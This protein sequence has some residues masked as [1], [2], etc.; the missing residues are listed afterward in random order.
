MWIVLLWLERE[1]GKHVV[2]ILI[3]KTS[4]FSGK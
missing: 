4:R 2:A 3:W 1:Y